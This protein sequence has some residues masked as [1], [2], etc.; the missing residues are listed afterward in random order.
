[1]SRCCARLIA[2][3][4]LEPTPG[5]FSDDQASTACFYGLDCTF[6][7]Q[8]VRVCAANTVDCRECMNAECLD[9]HVSSKAMVW[10][11]NRHILAS[12]A[13]GLYAANFAESCSAPN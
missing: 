2:L 10:S 13:Y 8:L 1:M 6:R 5:G 9:F 12:R 3:Q 11:F 7:N 4:I